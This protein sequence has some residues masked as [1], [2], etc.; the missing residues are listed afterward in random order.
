[1]ET[2]KGRLPMMW[3]FGGSEREGGWE[4]GE[5]VRGIG[6]AKEEGSEREEGMRREGEGRG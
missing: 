4:G 2:L 3:K 1:M 6:G 5:E